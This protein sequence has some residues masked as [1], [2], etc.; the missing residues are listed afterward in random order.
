MTGIYLR[1]A[2]EGSPS[3]K[4]PMYPIV[5]LRLMIQKSGMVTGFLCGCLDSPIS[6][7]HKKGGTY[8]ISHRKTP[9]A[10]VQSCCKGSFL[11]K[12]P[13]LFKD[14][15]QPL[16]KEKSAIRKNRK[17]NLGRKVPFFIFAP[18]CYLMIAFFPL[19]IYTPCLTGLPCRRRPS[20]VYHRELS[21]V[22][23]ILASSLML[24]GLL[25]SSPL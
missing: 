16:F 20:R 5:S 7:G 13:F 3:S 24:V 1:S 6:S 12:V 4:S 11:T 21:L 2:E 23:C 25:P 18:S 14:M 22:G 17:T 10:S 19:L 15:A 9:L 8:R